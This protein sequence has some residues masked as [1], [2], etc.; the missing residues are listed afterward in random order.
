MYKR[1]RLEVNPEDAGPKRVKSWAVKPVDECVPME[2]ISDHKMYTPQ[3]VQR[4]LNKQEKKIKQFYEALMEAKQQEFT[5]LLEER[6]NEQYTMF[7]RYTNEIAPIQMTPS[8]LSYI[9]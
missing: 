6:M 2:Q 7:I 1:Q 3:E 8:N 9:S 5:L 4:L